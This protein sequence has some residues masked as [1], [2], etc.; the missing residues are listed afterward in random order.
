MNWRSPFRRKTV[1]S[2]D[3]AAAGDEGGGGRVS[4]R[5]TLTRIA[6]V[7]AVGAVFAELR[8]GT[9]AAATTVGSGATAPAVVALTDAATISVDAS[10]GGDFRVTIAGNRTLGNPANPVDGQQII[11]QV[12]QGSGGG[13]T[14]TYGT[15]YEFGGSLPQP[16]LSTTAGH[17]D[18]L[19]F[20]YNAAK[21]TWMLAAFVNGFS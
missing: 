18:L 19:G 7:A 2:A 6:G 17:T 1:S 3:A 10:A 11:F 12:T 4:R 16:S 20:I 8:P 15:A 9:A 21:G 14:L 5:K 13:H